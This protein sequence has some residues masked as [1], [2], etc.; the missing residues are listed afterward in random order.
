MS[1]LSEQL[2]LEILKGNHMEHFKIAKDYSQIM[3]INDPRRKR[4]E[5]SANEL[6]DLIHNTKNVKK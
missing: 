5:D 4:I 1:K 3:D 6:V 2:R